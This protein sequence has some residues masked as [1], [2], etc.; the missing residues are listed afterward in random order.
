MAKQKINQGTAPTGVGGD[1]FRTGSAK[2]Q[3]NDDELYTQLGANAQGV[4]PA[5]LPL[6][7]GGTGANTKDSALVNLGLDKVIKSDVGGKLTKPISGG[8]AFSANVGHSVDVAYTSY[9]E[10]G[11]A[12]AKVGTLAIK[13]NVNTATS[14]PILVIRGFSTSYGAWRVTIVFYRSSLTSTSMHQAFLEGDIP[15][16]QLRLAVDKSNILHILLGTSATL[17]NYTTAILE[18]AFNF[19]Q[20]DSVGSSYLNSASFLYLT[21]QQEIDAGFTNIVSIS[22]KKILAVKATEGLVITKGGTGAITSA[23][24]R[25]NLGLGTAAI[26][27]AIVDGNGFIKTS[28][29]IL[30]LH[31]DRIEL[32]DEAQQ[33]NIVFEKL[34]IGDYL[35]K[36]SSGFAQEGWYVETPKDANGN[37]LFSVVYSTLENGDISVKTY[38]KKFDLETA[39]IIADLNNPI[40]IAENRWIDLRLQE[41]PQLE[42]VENIDEPE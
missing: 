17:W 36:G 25:T 41:L 13:F 35:I 2:L 20:G 6:S 37:V 5:A 27:N 1:T 28:S 12:S 21:D 26:L 30:K 3:A 40:D 16:E 29:P 39:S 31:T 32:N 23:G 42:I 7:V 10:A 8:G 14:I 19:Y 11:G 22:Y 33:Q 9:N 24:A 18:D 38:K 34:G 15:S 4:L